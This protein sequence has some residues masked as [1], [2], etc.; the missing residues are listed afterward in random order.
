MPDPE[1]V[2]NKKGELISIDWS[3]VEAFRMDKINEFHARVKEA[4][5]ANKMM[6]G[7]VEQQDWQKLMPEPNEEALSSSFDEETDLPF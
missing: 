7:E 5:A 4:A 6:A 1:E 3:E 2:F